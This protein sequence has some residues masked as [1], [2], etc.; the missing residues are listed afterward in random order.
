M[1]D[2]FTISTTFQAL[3]DRIPFGRFGETC[4]FFGGTL[5]NRPTRII[6]FFAI[7]QE[8]VGQS[9]SSSNSTEISMRRFYAQNFM[10]IGLAFQ[11]LSCKRTAGR[12]AGHTDRFYSVLTF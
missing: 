6:T 8:G 10:T 9:F 3:Q 7:N 4:V 5:W 1:A 2:F 12:P 11:A